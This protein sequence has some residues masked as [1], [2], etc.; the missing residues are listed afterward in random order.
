MYV[1]NYR[2]YLQCPL[3]EEDRDKNYN[4]VTL[5]HAQNEAER[6][7]NQNESETELHQRGSHSQDEATKCREDTVTGS[8]PKAVVIGAQAG[9]I[10]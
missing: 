6:R 8:K 1:C 3:N 5:P 9:L 2:C 10:A 7:W 4:V